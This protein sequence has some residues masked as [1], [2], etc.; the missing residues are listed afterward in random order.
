MAQQKTAE[1]LALEALQWLASEEELLSV[2]QGASGLNA[3][4]LKERAADPD[5]L[6]SVLD[7]VL[8]DDAWVISFCDR[9]G[10]PYASLAEAR[11]Q[12]PGGEHVHWT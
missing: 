10:V 1:V 7:F 2:F 3:D 9:A 12:L 5:L 11:A 8:M 4:D 6:G